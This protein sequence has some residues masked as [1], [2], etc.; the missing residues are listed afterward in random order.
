MTASISR[1]PITTPGRKVSGKRAISVFFLGMLNPLL[2]VGQTL[3]CGADQLI[4][5]L[6]THIDHKHGTAAI[7]LTRIIRGWNFSPDR[8][9][10][11]SEEHTSELQS[12]EKLVCRLLLEKKKHTRP[13]HKPIG[14]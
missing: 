8:D 11:R 12:R 1:T 6:Q 2:A 5:N 14:R 4:F 3:I 13:P 9:C 10:Q 7:R